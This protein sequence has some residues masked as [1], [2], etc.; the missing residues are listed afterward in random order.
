MTTSNKSL[1]KKSRIYAS[2]MFLSVLMTITQLNLNE[3]I[4]SRMNRA[5]WKF[6]HRYIEKV[7][8][9]SFHRH[10]IILCLR[11]FTASD[12]DSLQAAGS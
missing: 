2:S 11:H 9:I 3:I 10:K 4:E 7:K 12:F 8:T 5:T 1:G 6:Q